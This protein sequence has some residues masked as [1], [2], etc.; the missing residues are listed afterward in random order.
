ME[1][2]FN[3]QVVVLTL[4]FLAAYV[5]LRSL[6]VEPCEVLHTQQLRS[7]DSM[8][9]CAPD[10]ADFYPVATMRFPVKVALESPEPLMAG[11]P[12]T[13]LLRLTG[14]GGL[15]LKAGEIANSHGERIHLMLI[16]PSRSDYFHLHPTPTPE[17]G[18]FATRFQPALATTYTAFIEFV[19]AQTTR[20]IM[21][22]S[23][24]TVR[25]AEVAESAVL[26]G[27]VAN[28]GAFQLGDLTVALSDT[29]A[30]GWRAGQRQ[31]LRL[32]VTHRDG[33]PLVFEPV[34]LSYAHLVIF[35]EPLSGLAHAHPLDYALAT[36]P[37]ADPN[38]RFSVRLPEAGNYRL[39]A[40]FQIDGTLHQAPFDL[41]VR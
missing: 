20:R 36:E 18:V 21:A 17:P 10:E 8:E 2:F 3:R 25:N 15:P 34:M 12:G 4:G 13:L 41:A 31:E 39:W 7:G 19:S 32:T 28:L 23:S 24:I 9:F 16:D 14:P 30:A 38:L 1:S 22:A 27:P 35:D 33:R 6:P 37:K 26:P 11:Q 5:V 29:P 40:Q